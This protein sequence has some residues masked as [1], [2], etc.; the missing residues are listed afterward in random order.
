M[1]TLK[2]LLLMGVVGAFVLGPAMARA[3]GTNTPPVNLP[4]VVGEKTPSN[5]VPDE[6]RTLL[7]A[8]EAKRDAYQAAQKDLL[9][10]L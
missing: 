1:K 4:A 2:A 5:Q 9:A 7:R 3:G 6:V 10:Q 8:F